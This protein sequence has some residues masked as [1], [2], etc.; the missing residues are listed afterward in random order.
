MGGLLAFINVG[1]VK[2]ISLSILHRI[3]LDLPAWPVACSRLKNII[4]LLAPCAHV[5]QGQYL[6]LVHSHRSLGPGPWSASICGQ[7]GYDHGGLF[8]EI[9]NGSDLA[10]GSLLILLPH[11]LWLQL[12]HIPNTSLRSFLLKFH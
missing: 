2:S 9:Y 3:G 7:D 6:D 10:H 11:T 5:R 12:T 1:F 8:D 4:R